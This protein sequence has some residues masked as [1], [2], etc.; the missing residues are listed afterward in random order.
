MSPSIEF[1]RTI[2]DVSLHLVAAAQVGLAVLSFLLPRIMRW[3]A[4]I[5]R[6]PLLL[7][8]VFVIHSWFISLALLIWGVLTWRFA[9]E[10][11]RAPTDLSRWLCGAVAVFWGLRCILQWSH[12]SPSH[13]RGIPSRTAIHWT[14]FLGYA[15]W[16]GVYA[17]A[18]VGK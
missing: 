7:R 1:H 12:Y 18:A 3:E 15:A 10:M 16:A 11:A 9:T 13:W 6:M 5:A 17:L 14:L 8:D 4:D 2:L